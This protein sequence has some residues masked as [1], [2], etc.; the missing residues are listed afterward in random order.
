M[1]TYTLIVRE[2][3]AGKY[4]EPCTVMTVSVSATFD[5]PVAIRA[6]IDT[7]AHKMGLLRYRVEDDCP[8]DAQMEMQL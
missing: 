8:G 4:K 1:P 2:D 7:V 3:T 6:A 5:H